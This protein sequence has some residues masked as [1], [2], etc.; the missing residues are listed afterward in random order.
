MNKTNRKRKNIPEINTIRDLIDLCNSSFNYRG[1]DMGI[2]NKIK[3]QL[4]D[5]DEMIGMKGLKDTLLG[6]I[7]YYIQNLHCGGDDYL[8]TVIFGP[9]GCGKCFALDTPVLMFD[10]SVKLVQ[11]ICVGDKLMGD[12]S[13]FRKVVS[14]CKGNGTLYDIEQAGNCTYTVNGDHI[15][16]LIDNKNNLTDI[17]V[18]TYNSKSKTWKHKHMGYK[19]SVYFKHKQTALSAYSMGCTLAFSST[20][21]PHDYLVDDMENRKQLI[22]G[23][24]DTYFGFDEYRGMGQPIKF[25][26]PESFEV[27]RFLLDSLCMPYTSVYPNVSITSLKIHTVKKAGIRVKSVGE[28]VYYGFELDPDSV[29]R[30]FLLGDFTVVHNTT[31]AKIVG[32]LYKNMGVL[33][34]SGK[35]TLTHRD[36]F[37]AKYLGQT[38]IKTKR[39]L[40]RCKGGVLFLDEAYSLGSESSS[41][42]SYSKEA[43]DTVNSYLSEH[44]QDLCFIIAGYEDDIKNCFFPHNKGL[45]RRF[46]WV[47]RIDTYSNSDLALIFEKMIRN[48]YWHLNVAHPTLTRLIKNNKDLFTDGGGS[49]ENLYFKAKISHSKRVFTLGYKHRYVLTVP[50]LEAAVKMMESHSI[51]KEKDLSYL[52]LYM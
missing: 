6:Q 45:E 10:G 29:N 35:F 11:Y 9:P 49:M 18:N 34:D 26:N 21:I 33:S 12:D 37:I 25:N 41:K 40:E 28:G 50:D 36:D 31:I 46:Q 24:I 39:L 1:I 38:A 47:H 44:K 5:I 48:S 52:K 22:L 3:P 42:D 20:P 32:N 4:I 13:T 7:L 43:L 51:K 23:F 27:F 30:R 16:C 17:S 2:L 8:H 15:L 19:K 14:T